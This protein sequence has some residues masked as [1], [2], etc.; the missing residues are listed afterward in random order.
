[1]HRGLDKNQLI[2]IPTGSFA[3]L[4]ALTS[5]YAKIHLSIHGIDFIIFRKFFSNQVSMIL[6][7]AFAG[8]TSLTTL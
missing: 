6:T 8:L 7:G 5:M 3:G 4:T 2:Y 1:M